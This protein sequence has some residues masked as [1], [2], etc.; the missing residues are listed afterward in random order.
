VAS[1][2]DIL[3][4]FNSDRDDGEIAAAAVRK[5]ARRDRSG[6]GSWRA[7]RGR[8]ARLVVNTSDWLHSGFRSDRFVLQYGL[9]ILFVGA[10]TAVSAIL[11]L[12]TGHVLTFPYYAAVVFS[13]WLGI[14]P[15]LLSVIL[16]AQVVNYYW[17]PPI[18]SL[19]VDDQ[20]WPWYVV[21]IASTLL[22]LAWTWQRRQAQ[23]ALEATVAARTADLVRANEALRKEMAERQAAEAELQQAQTEVARTLR[24]ATVAETA[25]TIAH[26]INQPLAA[27][28]ANASACLR[29]L[30]REP[31]IMDLAREAAGCIVSDATRAAE[32]ITRVRA[33]LNKEGPQHIRLDINHVV[34]EVL[35]LSRGA[36]ERQGIALK[37]ELARSLPTILG[38]PVQLQQ[39]LWNLVSNSMEAM[40]GISGGARALTIATRLDESGAVV[41][42]VEDTGPGIDAKQAERV[43]DSF[44]TT[45]PT[46]IGVGL[47]I[48]RS[49]IEEHQGR[50]WL[51]PGRDRGAC[52][53][54]A[55]PAAATDDP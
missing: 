52:F 17:V 51:A 46:G 28:S 54:F 27:I 38:D 3:K 18:Y 14:G 35:N 4:D 49:I 1:S 53:C 2:R 7:D 44:Y 29:S 15:G 8:I 19:G 16:A 23:H 41:V 30:A 42:A 50:L 12:V 9:A 36:V 47:S 39:V 22:S 11:E 32:V 40:T 45:K 26:E 13:T 34:E 48:S 31:P 55:L 25:A 43:F 24:L 20:N 33:L 5:A 21:F 10:A 6:A 37:T